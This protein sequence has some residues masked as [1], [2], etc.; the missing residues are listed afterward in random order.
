[1]RLLVLVILTA[2]SPVCVSEQLYLQS[3]VRSYHFDAAQQYNENHSGVGV[4]YDLGGYYVAGGYYLNSL[5]RDSYYFGFGTERRFSALPSVGAGVMLGA[6]TGYNAEMLL[7]PIPY[8]F[9]G[10]R[11]FTLRTFLFPPM[12]RVS[13]GAVGLQLRIGFAGS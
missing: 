4:E 7:G 2:A 10:N 9:V 8:A 13:S 5:S 6:V 3:N 11:Y 12:E 1:M